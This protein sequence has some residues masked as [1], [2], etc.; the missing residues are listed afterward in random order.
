MDFVNT[1]KKV[2]DFVAPIKKVAA[3]ANSKR[4]FD[5]EMISAVRK[6]DKLYSIYKKSDLETVKYNF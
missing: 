2:I 5:T 1:F 6:K 3:K 4:W